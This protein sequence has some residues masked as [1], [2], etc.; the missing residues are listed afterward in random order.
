MLLRRA[1]ATGRDHAVHVL[2][3]PARAHPGSASGG[4]WVGIPPVAGCQQGEAGHTAGVAP[5]GGVA[6]PGL[7]ATVSGLVRATT[8]P[9]AP[10]TGGNGRGQPPA[11]V[12]AA[13]GAP[14]SGERVAT[15]N[16]HTTPGRGP[17]A[18]GSGRTCSPA[19]A[20]HT[21]GDRAGQALGAVRLSSGV[22]GTGVRGCARPPGPHRAWHRTDRS[23][24]PP[25]D[26][27]ASGSGGA[28][29]RASGYASP[30]G[31]MGGCLSGQGHDPGQNTAQPHRVRAGRAWLRLF[32]G[33]WRAVLG[34][35]RTAGATYRRGGVSGMHDRQA[36]DQGGRRMR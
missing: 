10:D 17:L 36:S 12:P 9:G 30:C 21:R 3:R 2:G 20:S 16:G 11:L 4:S 24:T 5:S 34:V 23:P 32:I 15:A 26:A 8:C 33:A 35:S 6:S 19:G 18:P 14:G 1:S 28:G 27:S 31:R 7:G 13:H 25:S 22:R 29:V